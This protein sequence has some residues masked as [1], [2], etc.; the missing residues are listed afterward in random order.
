MVAAAG[1][2]PEQICERCTP[3]G[4]SSDGSVVLLQKYDL[5]D[6]DKDRI[7]ALDLRTR[8]EQDFLSLSGHSPV[9]HAFFSWDD[10]WVVFQKADRWIRSNTD[11]SQILIAPVRHGSAAARSGMDRGHRRTAQRR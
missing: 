1:G 2:E 10:R 6:A 3:R 4:F 9:A 8:T 5:T 11:P 7:V